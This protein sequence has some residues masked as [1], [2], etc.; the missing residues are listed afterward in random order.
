MAKVERRV[1]HSAYYPDRIDVDQE[2]GGDSMTRQEFLEECDI[3]AIM[4]RYERTGTVP[5]HGQMPQYLDLTMYPG[6]LM[7]AM[8]QMIVA[9]EAFMSLPALV[10]KEFDND[11]MRFVE[12]A[13]NGDNVDKLREWGLAPPAPVE[14]APMRV[15][16][17]NPSHPD[18]ELETEPAPKPGP[19]KGQKK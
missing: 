17:V 6:D 15:E 12:F 9:E 16:V 13:S 7:G 11:A 2:P 19:D 18:R 3:N 10:R 4:A 8:N 1:L 5:Y 14:E